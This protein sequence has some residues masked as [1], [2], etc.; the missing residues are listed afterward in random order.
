MQVRLATCHPPRVPARCRYLAVLAWSFALFNAL[1]LLA[2][3]PTIWAIYT[4]GDSQQHSW[5]TWLT[6]VG[7]NVTMAAW[8]YEDAQRWTRAVAV[9]ACNA[10][11][12][13]ATLVLILALRM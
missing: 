7:A 5:F 10:M 11:M 2:Y 3:L 12:C 4:S 9:N 13:F 6:W 8:L 1:R